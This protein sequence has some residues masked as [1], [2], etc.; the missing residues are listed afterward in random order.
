MDLLELPYTV[1]LAGL[2]PVLLLGAVWL[3]AW[4]GLRPGA[5]RLAAAAPVLALH[6]AAPWLLFRRVP[7]HGPAGPGEPDPDIVT[8][9]L[10][11]FALVWLANFKV[12]WWQGAAGGGAP[13]K[14]A[15]RVLHAGRPTCYILPRLPNRCWPG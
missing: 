2:V 9:V 4:R 12:G 1:R 7:P 5:P 15:H 14:G 8:L 6:S 10:L 13:Q 11:E 3:S